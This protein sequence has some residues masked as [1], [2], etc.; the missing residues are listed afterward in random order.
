M[1][2]L[3][4]YISCQK[5]CSARGACRV[6][7]GVQQLHKCHCTLSLPDK[8]LNAIQKYLFICLLF[9]Q[10]PSS[11]CFDLCREL[12]YL[13]PICEL[14]FGRILIQMNFLPCIV[15]KRKLIKTA[16]QHANYNHTHSK[17]QQKAFSLIT[18]QLNAAR[19]F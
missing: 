10:L 9:S 2:K 5:C 12:I 8:I 7:D 4:K 11:K 1:K 18:A 14:S 13:D 6:F 16:A 3:S 19:G 17:V 15:T